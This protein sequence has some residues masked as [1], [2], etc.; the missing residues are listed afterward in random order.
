M[1]LTSLVDNIQL[2]LLVVAVLLMVLDAGLG[3][4]IAKKKGTFQGDKIPEFLKTNVAPF[5]GGLL[6]LY[7]SGLILPELMAVYIGVAGTV[8]WRFGKDIKQKAAEFAES[9]KDPPPP[10]S[11]A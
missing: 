10:H 3:S 1:N 6:V 5:A 8:I 9:F 4:V 11:P 2:K 7:I